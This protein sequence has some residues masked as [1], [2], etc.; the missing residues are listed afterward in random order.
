MKR[1]NPPGALLVRKMAQAC[2]DSGEYKTARLAELKESFHN[3]KIGIGDKVSDAQACLEN[4]LETYLIP[5]YDDDD[6]EDLRDM[7]RETPL[8]TV[9]GPVQVVGNWGQIEQGIFAGKKYPAK[10]FAQWLDE[11]AKLF[12]QL[13]RLKKRDKD[14][15][16]D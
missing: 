5:H 3:L 4:G 7:A 12:D 13:E 1:R 15:D 16:N 2:G 6:P 9:C 14:E 10:R 11:Q 8:L